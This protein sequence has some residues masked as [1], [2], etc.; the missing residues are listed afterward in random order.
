LSDCT[1]FCSGQPGAIIT[2]PFKSTELHKIV[3]HDPEK[4]P[5][6]A[7]YAAPNILSLQCGLALDEFEIA[8]YKK[9]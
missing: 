8:Q 4:S 2:W 6:V 7:K 9:Y 1:G 3:T 5:E